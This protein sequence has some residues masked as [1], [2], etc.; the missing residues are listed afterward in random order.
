MEA[1]GRYVINQVRDAGGWD[2]GGG[3]GGQILDP[4]CR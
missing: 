1:P 3:S 2:Q 4:F